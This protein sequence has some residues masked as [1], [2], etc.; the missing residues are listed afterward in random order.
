[1]LGRALLSAGLLTHRSCRAWSSSAVLNDK[2]TPRGRTSAS[3]K[4]PPAKKAPA[5]KSA[6]QQEEDVDDIPN[7]LEYANVEEAVAFMY[8]T[9]KERVE[10]LS[11]LRQRAVTAGS[12][13]NTDEPSSVQSLVDRVR[14]RQIAVSEST[15]IAEA[16]PLAK[17]KPSSAPSGAYLMRQYRTLLRRPNADQ[18]RQLDEQ[19]KLALPS[20]NGDSLVKTLRERF[21]I[22]VSISGALLGQAAA[23]LCGCI[24]KLSPASLAN[25]FAALA[26]LSRTAPPPPNLLR[27]LG[28]QVEKRVSEF[29]HIDLSTLLNT[30]TRIEHWQPEPR[31]F[32]LLENQ[33]VRLLTTFNA[34][35]IAL[36]LNGFARAEHT[37]QRFSLHL[38][39]QH[40]PKVQSHF[41]VQHL[42]LVAS[43]LAFQAA[44]VPHDAYHPSIDFVESMAN[45]FCSLIDQCPP[46]ATANTLAALVKLGYF[47]CDD[48]QVQRNYDDDNNNNNN[49][50]EMHAA[51]LLTKEQQQ[52]K[53]REHATK[54]CL[55]QR[56]QKTMR[57][58]ARASLFARV[59]EHTERTL[60]DF[61]AQELSVLLKTLGL[62]RF[63]PL[64]SAWLIRCFDRARRLLSSCQPV[65]LLNFLAAVIAFADIRR[66]DCR[67]TDELE[68]AIVNSLV[69]F[70][71]S[72]LIAVVE[73]LSLRRTPTD[74]NLAQTIEL[75]LAQIVDQLS[76]RDVVAFLRCSPAAVRQLSVGFIESLEARCL[77]LVD[78]LSP[79][80][81]AAMIVG[82]AA[83]GESDIVPSIDTVDRLCR[84][85][86]STGK[87][88]RFSSDELAAF[89]ETLDGLKFFE[90]R[91]DDDDEDSIRR[92]RRHR[93][94]RQQQHR[95]RLVEREDDADDDDE[96]VSARELQIQV[97]TQLLANAAVLVAQAQTPPTEYARLVQTIATAKAMSSSHAFETAL[98]Q[99]LVDRASVLSHAELVRMLK[100]CSGLHGRIR[101]LESAFTECI[102]VWRANHKASAAQDRELDAVMARV[103]RRF[104]FVYLGQAASQGT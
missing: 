102:D 12:A 93:H 11:A 44:A 13:D 86:V 83:C 18:L 20:L 96:N 41:T 42:A 29:N 47:T 53:H 61:G 55:H 69:D 43:A 50:K 22:N 24:D 77:E 33:C 15:K 38:F 81:A 103:D 92:R 64:S 8:A 73:L 66:T 4:K 5:K 68:I 104:S 31:V 75:E 78:E 84:R 65:G 101:R 72:E 82:L 21:A 19:L 87:P 27:Q 6:R 80:T 7:E 58:A 59:E 35:D 14:A 16:E 36:A 28:E 98:L 51:H 46:Q 70:Q 62:A 71:P 23:V 85:A 99:S 56:G 88:L 9:P 90:R 32:E 1:M 49:D 30:M 91:D 39:E 63:R 79:R 67:F 37:L 2:P 10:L 57:A 95:G 3:S 45:R 17:G 89:I 34:Q 26:T 48:M 100:S 52:E 25:L 60:G 40:L 76:Q 74:P 94:Q 97:G 54:A